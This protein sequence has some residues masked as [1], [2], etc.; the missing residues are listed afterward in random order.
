[1]T[2]HVWTAANALM[3]LMFAF[4]AI[5][6]FNDPDPSRW[7]AIYAAA[8]LVCGFELGRRVKPMLAALISAAALAWAAS[9]APRVIGKVRFPA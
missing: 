4:S 8:T 5:V 7:I 3:L 9:I 6:Q 1:M 2:R